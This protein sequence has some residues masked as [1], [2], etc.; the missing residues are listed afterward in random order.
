MEYYPDKSE[1]FFIDESTNYDGFAS[2]IIYRGY[3]A[4]LEIAKKK[5]AARSPAAIRQEAIHKQRRIAHRYFEVWLR[6]GSRPLT[7]LVKAD[8]SR[9]SRRILK[10]ALADAAKKY[11][12]YAKL[13]GVKL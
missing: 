11:P 5:R 10:K 2:E 12:E 13:R 6:T 7:W 1:S 3:L 8:G 9:I 4:R